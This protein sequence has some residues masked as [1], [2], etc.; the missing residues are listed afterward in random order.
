MDRRKTK[1]VCTLGPASDS[2][3]GIA[4]LLDA[5]MD[6]A[7]LNFSHGRRED[8]RATIRRIREVA[9]RRG[10]EVGILQDLGGPKIRLGVLPDDGIRLETGDEVA[11]APAGGTAEGVLPVD[12][13]HLLEDVAAG[14]TIL[15][16]DG[17]AELEVLEVLADRLRCRVVNGGLVTSRKGVNLP[18]AKLR[19]PAVTDKDFADLEVGLAEGV[20]LVALSFVRHEDDLAPVRAR[21]VDCEHP[22][23]LVA[24]IEKP[25]AVDRLGPIIEA[26]DAVM[27]ARGDLGVEMPPEK[28]PVIQKRII[29]AARLAGRP[30]ITATQ[31]LRSMVDSPRPLRAEASDVANAVFDGTDALM[32]SEETAI[33]SFPAE[34]VQ[35]LDRIAR[36]TE[37]YLERGGMPVEADPAAAPDITGAISRAACGLAEAIG[38]AAIVTTTSSGSTARLIARHRP[39]APVLGVTTSETVAR[40]LHLSWGVIPSIVE[41]ISDPKALAEALVGEL[42]DRGIARSGDHVVLAAGLPLGFS[43]AANGIRIHRVE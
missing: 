19:V 23:M 5:G 41:A 25:Q 36:E 2:A 13:D 14:E 40:Q 42:T 1:I 43:D 7:R 18:H 29:A 16:A 32:L 6:V 11:L 15:L 3:A 4:A 9:A 26:V 38:A 21:L 37:A 35:M 31:M 39:A 28:V 34:A 30:V 10:R 17:A 27:V 33:G 8:H 22:P 20:D 12:Y 24:K